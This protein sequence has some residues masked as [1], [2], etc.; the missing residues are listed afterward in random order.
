MT[1]PAVY[2]K[3]PANLRMRSESEVRTRDCDDMVRSF[4]PGERWYAAEKGAYL[5]RSHRRPTVATNTGQE[6][7]RRSTSARPAS[8]IETNLRPGP[9][10]PSPQRGGTN[11]PAPRR[12]RI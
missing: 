8:V 1:A 6:L 9:P 11:P 5:G 4:L 12:A 3:T 2:A 7:R 10:P